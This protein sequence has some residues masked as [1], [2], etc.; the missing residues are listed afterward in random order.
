LIVFAGGDRYF[1]PRMIKALLL[2][3]APVAIWDRIALS[4]RRWGIVFLTYFLPLLLLVSFAEGYGLVHFGKPR[5]IIPQIQKIPVGYAVV[6]ELA[7][8]ALAIAIVFI[9][10]RQIKSL[11]D[12]FHGRHTFTQA[13]TVAAYGM[14]PV[15]FLRA[16]DAFAAMPSWVGWL[17]GV[18]LSASVLYHGIPRVMKPDPPHALGLYFMSVFLLVITTGLARF[19]MTWFVQGR[20]TKLDAWIGRLTGGT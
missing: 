2:I 19:L 8:V 1:F 12:T 9:L 13:F 17:I 16:F 11:G 4:Q 14:G 7:Q 18:A 6:Y 3:F 10:A 20:F 15:L 5:G